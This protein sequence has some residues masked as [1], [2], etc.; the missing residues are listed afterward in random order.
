M[1]I[2][3]YR[4]GSL[5]EGALGATTDEHALVDQPKANR[6]LDGEL[7]VSPQTANDSGGVNPGRKAKTFITRKRGTAP[8][9]TKN[10]SLRRSKTQH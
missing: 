7:K 8:P 9:A 10:K 1:G 3:Q 5:L 4:M 6:E 2:G